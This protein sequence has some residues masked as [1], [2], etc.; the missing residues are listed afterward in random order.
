MVKKYKGSIGIV[1]AM[2]FERSRIIVI[3]DFVTQEK[4]HY[5]WEENEY[6]LRT[7]EGDNKI[8]EGEY[9]IK[10]KENEYLLCKPDEFA[11]FYEEID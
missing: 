10:V 4:M 2:K 7:L 11:K 3:M 1:E 8:N 6:Y 9:V 5:S